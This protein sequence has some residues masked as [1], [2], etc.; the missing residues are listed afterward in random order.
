MYQMAIK[1]KKWYKICK[2]TIKF[3]NR[4]KTLPNLPKLG[5]LFENKTSGNPGG[6]PTTY[7][8]A[9]SLLILLYIHT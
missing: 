9:T 8:F 3:T 6:N 1:Y 5:F 7:Y 4:C 2:I